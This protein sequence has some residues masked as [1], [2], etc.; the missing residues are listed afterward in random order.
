MRLRLGWGDG[1]VIVTP[2]SLGPPPCFTKASLSTISS[3]AP[4]SSIVTIAM[5]RCEDAGVGTAAA[6]MNPV[7]SVIDVLLLPPE[8]GAW[9]DCLTDGKWLSSVYC[10]SS[11]CTSSLIVA[12]YAGS[13]TQHSSQTA[14]VSAGIWRGLSS[15]SG[16]RLVIRLKTSVLLQV[17]Y[18]VSA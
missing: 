11:F 16:G 3:S 10:L 1:S 18:G 5:F 4:P 8:E 12:L 15:S 6:S 9:L 14:Y 2:T 17:G 7:G 13:K